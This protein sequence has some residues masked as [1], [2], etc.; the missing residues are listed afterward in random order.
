MIPELKLLF[1]FF[2]GLFV[3]GIT[4]LIVIAVASPT[5]W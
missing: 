1:G 5:G 4:M 3:A 2:L